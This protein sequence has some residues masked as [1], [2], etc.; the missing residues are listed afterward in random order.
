MTRSSP[1]ST[2]STKS[3]SSGRRAGAKEASP[4]KIAV[5]VGNRNVGRKGFGNVGEALS[6]FF[7]GQKEEFVTPVIEELRQT[8]LQ[9]QGQVKQLQLRVVE[10]R[11]EQHLMQES[12]RAEVHRLDGVDARVSADMENLRQA[13]AEKPGVIELRQAGEAVSAAEARLSSLEREVESKVTSARVQVLESRVPSLE[14]GA[15]DGVE[16]VRLLEEGLAAVR[17]QSASV[18]QAMRDKIGLAH[19]RQFEGVVTGIQAQIGNFE[20][21]LQEKVGS[22]QIQKLK[23]DI[24]GTEAKLG[25]LD[26]V[27]QEKVGIGQLQQ[28]KATMMGVET[29]IIG[30]EQAVQEKVGS[31]QI[32]QL[33]GIIMSIQTQLTG[34][35]QGVKEK[36][37]NEQL[38]QLKSSI[39]NAQAQ[40]TGVEVGM[41]EKVGHTQLQQVKNSVAGVESKVS[42]VEQ[43][44]AEKVSSCEVQQLGETLAGV[45]TKLAGMERAVWEG[46]DCVQQLE[47][48]ISSV[49]AQAST[50][51]QSLRDKVSAQ[52]LQSYAEALAGVKSKV[53][54]MERAVV[55]GSE[56]AQQ[57]EDAI[58]SLGSQFGAFRQA[59]SMR[60]LQ[61]EFEPPRLTP[62]NV[63][64]GGS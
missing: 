15:K 25:D 9:L 32:Q 63:D 14:L 47:G 59:G 40:I 41:H 2:A 22:V 11:Q 27:M 35:E 20:Q 62:S 61:L 51:D 42:G 57:V 28:L 44:L 54:S 30:V 19:I 43:A 46:M 7:V 4:R 1:S 36:V 55:A 16:K 10:V 8:L 34:L 49:K 3:T 38:Q 13:L 24:M 37:G 53:G 6:R 50:I 58:G 17:K 64:A 60:S 45:Q 39:A 21:A 18:D 23:A 52:E 12:T 5:R 26:Q 56:R 33:K 29:K 31:G 48:V